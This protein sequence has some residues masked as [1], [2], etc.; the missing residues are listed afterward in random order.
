MNFISTKERVLK[1]VADALVSPMENPYPEVDLEEDVFLSVQKHEDVR[2][3]ENFIAIGGKFVYSADVEEAVKNLRT[4]GQKGEWT[5]KIFCSDDDIACFLQK[6]GLRFGQTERDAIVKSVAFFPVH[7]LVADTGSVVY[8]IREYARYAVA[9]AQT[10]VFVATMD[11][12]VSELKDAYKTVKKK[13][14]ILTT[15]TSVFSGLSKI[16][17][18][19]GNE[20]P[21][22]GAKEVY[23]FLIE[24]ADDQNMADTDS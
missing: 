10:L 14:E 9:N 22:F 11:Q 24:V 12:L 3:A 20:F 17:D 19:D 8:P 5:G 18:V 2:F 7:A 15:I 16:T 13:A 21:G 1:K 23:L 4:F 6:A